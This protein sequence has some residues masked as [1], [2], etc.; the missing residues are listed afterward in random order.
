MKGGLQIGYIT[1]VDMGNL[2]SSFSGTNVIVIKKIKT[3]IGDE[4]PYVSGQMLRHIYREKLQEMGWKLSQIQP[5]GETEGNPEEYIDDDI[6]GFMATERKERGRKGKAVTRTSPIKVSAMV[7]LYPLLGNKD[8]LVRYTIERETG[9]KIGEPTPVEQEFTGMNYFKGVILIDLDA[10]GKGEGLRKEIKKKKGKIE[11]IF[12]AT[13]FDIPEKERKQRV[14]AFIDAFRLK[15]GGA[16]QARMLCDITPKFVVGIKQKYK[17]PMLL[18]AL[19]VDAEGK[20][21]LEPLT[22]VLDQYED[23]DEKVVVGIRT[24]IFKNE[25]DVKRLFRQRGM[26]ML[27]SN[28]A[29]IKMKEWV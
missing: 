20:I 29:L 1:Y 5:T 9:K 22:A 17:V 12:E 13:K 8:L 26:E 11:T 15:F 6:F 4:Y 10:I 25:D 23:I 27:D 16:K 18:D 7:G 28:G 14:N 19:K 24:G 21:S 3:P 2:N